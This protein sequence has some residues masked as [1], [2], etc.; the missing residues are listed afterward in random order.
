MGGLYAVRLKF[1]RTC[2]QNPEIWEQVWRG[3]RK[4]EDDAANDEPRPGKKLSFT[5]AADRGQTRPPEGGAG[6][7]VWDD[8]FPEVVHLE[9]EEAADNRLAEEEEFEV[10]AADKER[11]LEL[12][13][14]E[15]VRLPVHFRSLHE[16]TQQRIRR[17]NA[18]FF[19]QRGP[20]SPST[21]SACSSAGAEDTARPRMPSCVDQSFETAREI[22][23]LA[24]Y[25]FTHALDTYVLDGWVT[26]HVRILQELA[27]MYRTLQFWEKDPKR[28]AAMLKRR[29]RMLCPC[30]EQ[31]SPKVYVAFWRQLSFSCAE[32]WQELYEL[33]ANGKLPASHGKQSIA[34]D[35]AEDENIT[36]DVK[37]IARCNELAK[38][39]I[40]YYTIF[41]DSYHPDGKTVDR[42]DTDHA[43]TYLTAKLNRARLR[44]KMQGLSADDNIE[45]HSLALQDYQDMIAYGQRNQEVFTDAVGMGQ[46]MMLV[47]EMAAMLPSKLARLAAKRR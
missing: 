20:C 11:L 37:Q 16:H 34:V 18:K 41:I 44:T 29:A 42:V 2:A 22:F 4:K 32:I 8:V 10:D 36:T 15:R 14:G 33:K 25:F 7:I 3:E 38:Q 31:L 23:K 21:V 47:Q 30:L 24:S 12:R 45:G 5:C 26:E 27:T 13:D 35:D 1:A 43:N 28:S 19:E 17:A 40:K 39:S 9:D 6:E 46:E